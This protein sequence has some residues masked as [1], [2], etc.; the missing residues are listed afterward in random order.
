MA[1]DPFWDSGCFDL[2]SI[3]DIPGRYPASGAAAAHTD[4]FA[5]SVVEREPLI[6]ENR[7][8]NRWKQK[9]NRKKTERKQDYSPSVMN[10]L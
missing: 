7:Y 2:G 5:D 1:V 9:E 6:T 4:L 10:G 3:F 8:E